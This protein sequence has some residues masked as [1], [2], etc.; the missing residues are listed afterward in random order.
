MIIA[1]DVRF[2]II[3]QQ[4]GDVIIHVNRCASVWWLFVTLISTLCEEGRVIFY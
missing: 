4:L 3:Q 1:G 2:V